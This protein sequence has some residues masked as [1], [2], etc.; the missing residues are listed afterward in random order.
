MPYVYQPRVPGRKRTIFKVARSSMPA[1]RGAGVKTGWKS[2]SAL[3]KMVTKLVKGQAETKYVAD[4]WDRN[5]NAALPSVW[6]VGSL[7]AGAARFLPMIPRCTQGTDDNERIGDTITPSG[8][9][10]TTLNFAINDDISGSHQ[11]LV[12]VYYGVTKDRKS[13]DN[14]N[15]L[16]TASFLDNGD[17]TN[18]S[19]TFTRVSGMLPVQKDLVSFKKYQFVLSKAA[20]TT[21]GDAGT[22]NFSANAGKSY[23]SITLTHSP[24]KKLK[25]SVGTDNFPSNY[26]PGYFISLAYADGAVPH[27]E[28]YLN[29]L[30]NVT[31]RTH[32]WFKDM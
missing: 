2:K 12:T 20:G 25:Y 32:M 3:R 31:A 23:R 28:A 8:K 14:Q 15:A 4:A 5:A 26:A 30:V 17:G 24:P 9:V 6:T 29:G 7:G 10:K 16:S 27:T 21:G 18:T 13:W 19:P 22:G 11:I 1:L